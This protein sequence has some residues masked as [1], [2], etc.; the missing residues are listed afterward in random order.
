[1]GDGRADVILDGTPG[2]EGRLTIVDYKTAAAHEVKHELQLQ[3]YADAGRREGLDVTQALVHDM[4]TAT[5]IPVD[6][7]DK[8]IQA[9]E[10]T[11][12]RS[13]TALKRREFNP[14][15]ER[16][17]CTACDVKTICPHSQ[18]K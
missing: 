17:R 11:V 10:I 2:N 12:R 9:A 7:S 14:N 5:R 18:A 16:G 15:P 4:K 6:T 13:A 8:A 3:I 1:M